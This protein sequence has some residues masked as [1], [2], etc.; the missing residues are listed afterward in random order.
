M[1]NNSIVLK[2]RTLRDFLMDWRSQTGW[3]VTDGQDQNKRLIYAETEMGAIKGSGLLR[4]HPVHEL[5]VRRAP[6]ADGLKNDIYKL[7][8]VMREN[9]WNV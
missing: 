5:H 3:E 1:E 2:R 7:V 6:Y 9:G 8:E 4:D